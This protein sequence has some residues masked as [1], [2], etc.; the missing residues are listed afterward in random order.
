MSP[1]YIVLALVPVAVVFR[2]FTEQTQAARLIW[3]KL[4]SPEYL[5]IHKNG[6]QDAVSI[7]EANKWFF[8][9]LAL[10]IG[11]L[12]WLAMGFGWLWALAGLFAALPELV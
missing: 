7:P 12:T 8:L 2:Y 6:F 3:I 1:L 11:G 9:L 4:A 10:L 5:R